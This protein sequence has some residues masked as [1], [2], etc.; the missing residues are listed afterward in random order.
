[1][2]SVFQYI[3]AIAASPQPV[4]ITGETGVGKELVARAVHA[5]SNRKGAFLPVNVAGLDDNVFADTLF[6]RRVFAGA[7]F[8]GMRGMG[9]LWQA[10]GTVD[11]VLRPGL[12]EKAVACGLRS[13]F[14]GF[15]TLG[16]GSL[17][18]Q[19]KRHNLGRDYGAAVRRLHDLGV[20]VNASF[21]FG[22]DDDDPTVFDRTVEWAVAQGVETATFHVLTPYPGTELFRRMEAQGRLLH[23]DWDLYDT[24]HCVISH[25]RMTTWQIEAGYRRARNAFYSWDGVV[26]ASLARETP[27]ERVRHF[28]YS[29][30]WK[31]AEPLWD[32]VIRLGLLPYARPALEG[33]L[34]GVRTLRRAL[35]PAGA[36]GVAD[37]GVLETGR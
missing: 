8:D 16:S 17:R 15:E 20:M 22:F 7:L 23:R 32:A 33:V 35:R 6:G 31:K 29:A 27:S 3:E 24:R 4:L 30:A 11:A 1:M 19:G 28:A 9:R 13:L 14:V 25:P 37:G 18:A 34:D 21:V 36:R 12:L 2:R 26:R 10:A 5:L